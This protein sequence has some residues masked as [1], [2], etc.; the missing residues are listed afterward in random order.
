M[1]LKSPYAYA[2]APGAA[3]ELLARRRHRPALLMRARRRRMEEEQDPRVRGRLVEHLARAFCASPPAFIR[4]L[5]PAS[6]RADLDLRAERLLE[7][8]ARAARMRPQREDVERLH[9][10]SRSLRPLAY[11]DRAQERPVLRRPRARC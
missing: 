2:Q 11:H 4:V 5:V 1:S 6:D 9:L 8:E 10:D 3:L 7:K